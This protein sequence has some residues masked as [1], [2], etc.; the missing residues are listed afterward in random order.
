M[1]IQAQKIERLAN[2][3]I[4][5]VALLLGIVVVRK[6][7]LE[8]RS[9]SASPS[10][11]V[12]TKL[13]IRD[14]DWSK[15]QDTLLLVLRE[16]CRYCAES[17]PF[18]QRLVAKAS[19]NKDLRLI[20]V[21]PQNPGDARKYLDTLG[22]T[23]AEVREATLSEIGVTGTPTLILLNNTGVVKTVWVGELPADKEKEVLEKI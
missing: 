3:A 7:L 15:S 16:G 4:I 18:Y 2:V 10:V 5:V 12:G 9:N 6:Y 14:V 1:S 8:A 20:A 21:L 19:G 23:I 11:A 22:V 17:A 13:S